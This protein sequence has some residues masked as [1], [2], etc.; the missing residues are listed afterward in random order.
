MNENNIIDGIILIVTC[1]KYKENRKKFRLKK[2]KYLNWQVIYLYGNINLENDY[3]L[4]DNILTVKCEDTYLH[5]FKK[6]ILG[7]QYLEKIYTIKEGILRC[8]DDLIFYEENLLTFLNLKNKNDYIGKNFSRKDIESN[9]ISIDSK[10]HN[11]FMINYYNN[12]DK[13]ND[14]NEINKILASRNIKINDLNS[15]P[16]LRNFIALGHIFYIS[17]RSIQILVK[18]FFETY[19]GDILFSKNNYYPFIIEDIGIGYILFNNKINMTHYKNMWYNPHYQNFDDKITCPE[20]ICF[21]TNEGN[22]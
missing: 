16:N 9:T 20:P 19:N 3:E 4:K 2:D 8:G 7:I 15:T 1:D 22:I 11:N 18:D 13:E 14:K 10:E 5:L 21:H 17:K 6:I 12:E